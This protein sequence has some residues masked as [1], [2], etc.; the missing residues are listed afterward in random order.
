MELHVHPNL[1]SSPCTGV[2]LSGSD[3]LISNL[4]EVAQFIPP[5]CEHAIKL[6]EA[7]QLGPLLA[8]NSCS[9]LHA[10]V[11]AAQFA[12]EQTVLDEGQSAIVQT[13]LQGGAASSGAWSIS[14][15]W[16]SL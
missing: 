7:L 5:A 12:L 15:A 10:V 9:Q 8:A 13:E 3:V 4:A 1:F 16:A 2:L 6:A 11:S 14:V